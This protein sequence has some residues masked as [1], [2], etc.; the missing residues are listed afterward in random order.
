ME[1]CL[2]YIAEE[3][4]RYKK[5][6]M[7]NKGQSYV[8]DVVLKWYLGCHAERIGNPDRQKMS[9]NNHNLEGYNKTDT[10]QAFVGWM[11]FKW[12]QM[13]ELMSTLNRNTQ[14]W[15]EIDI[16]GAIVVGE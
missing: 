12:M 11:N 4:P 10:V 6:K 7:W 15:I 8:G 5:P 9:T 2:K 1:R 3:I 13:D 14:Q 16:P